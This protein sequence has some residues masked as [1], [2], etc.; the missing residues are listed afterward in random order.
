MGAEMEWYTCDTCTEADCEDCGH[1]FYWDEG[2][3]DME[4]E[5]PCCYS[6]DVQV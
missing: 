6:M 3:G 5:C 1:G 4:V 2:E